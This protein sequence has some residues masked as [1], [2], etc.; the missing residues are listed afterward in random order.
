MKVR[1]FNLSRI[2]DMD[3]LETP[4]ETRATGKCQYK[5]FSLQDKLASYAAFSLE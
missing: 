3:S 2:A 4:L 1:V 5:Q